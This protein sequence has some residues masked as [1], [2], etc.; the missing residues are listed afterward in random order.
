MRSVVVVGALGVLLTGCGSGPSVVTGGP[1]PK[2]AYAGPMTLPLDYSD[3]AGVMERSGAAGRALECDGTPFDGGGGDYD[4]GLATTQSSAEAALSNLFKEDPPTYPPHDGY[5]V[6]RRGDGRVLFSYDVD[7]RT[8]VA[9]IAADDIRDWDHHTGWGVESWAQCDP[10]EL[11]DG[12]TG[13]FALDVWTDAAGVRA[14]V[15]VIRSYQGPAH[16]DWQ[17]VTFLELGPEGHATTYLRDPHGTLADFVRTSYSKAVLLPKEAVDTGYH[18]DGRELWT[19]TAKDAAYLVSRATPDDVER[20]PAE[21][22]PIGC[23]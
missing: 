23:D 8:K 10:A 1:A 11:P 7:G 9:F 5:R 21:K 16:C 3:T 4:S 12:A 14:P 13:S 18:R 22:Q 19:V 2:A 20:W 17:D 15:S 6:E